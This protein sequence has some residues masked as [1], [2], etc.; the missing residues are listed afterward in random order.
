MDNKNLN[1]LIAVITLIIAILGLG[2]SLFAISSTI[3][4]S[5]YAN[6]NNAKWDIHFENLSKVQLTGYAQEIARPKLNKDS[7]SINKFKVAFNSSSDTAA[8]EF[9]VVNSGDIDARITTISILNPICIGFSE[10]VATAVTDAGIVCNNFKYEL[11]Y[12]N[13]GRIMINDLLPAGSKKTLKLI[14]RYVGND[15]PMEK[16]ELTDLSASIIYSQN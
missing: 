5:G 7:T 6:V 16:V 15:W 3:K 9:N 1:R 10:D 8:Y 14:M 13:G 11:F 2:V 12:V 4:I